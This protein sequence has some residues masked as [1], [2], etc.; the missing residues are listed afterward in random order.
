MAR[1]GTLNS[2][3][4]I[5]KCQH[6]GKTLRGTSMAPKKHK[7]YNDEE[8]EYYYDDIC[9]IECDDDID[10][11]IDCDSEE[12]SWTWTCDDD[13]LYEPR[14]DDDELIYADP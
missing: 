8:E 1:N 4:Q 3:R 14:D 7:K 2:P 10:D 6:G 11:D 12:W 5:F 9:D 13:Y